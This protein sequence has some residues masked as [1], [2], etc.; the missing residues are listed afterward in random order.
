MSKVW[1]TALFLSLLWCAGWPENSEAAPNRSF[2]IELTPAEGEDFGDTFATARSLGLQF[3]SLS[4]PWDEI[5]TAPGQFK[6]GDLESANGFFP[7]QSVPL[8]LTISVIDTNILRVPEDLREQ[9]FSSPQMKARFHALLDFVFKQLKDTQLVALAIGNEV[10]ALLGEDEQQWADYLNFFQDAVSYTHARKRGT[11]VGV[12]FGFDG[13]RSQR[14]KPFIAASDTAM[15]TY[16]PLHPDFTVRPPSEVESDFGLM[17]AASQ[18]KTLMILECGFP[19]AATNGSSESLQ[20]DFVV[21]MFKAWDTYAGSISH[22]SYFSLTDFGDE[23]VGD[24]GDYYGVDSKAFVSYLSSLG[25]R[26][27][28][29]KKKVAFD[30]LRGEK[31]KLRK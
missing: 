30:V 20:R 18:G 26:A 14:A 9:S 16:Y 19:S 11:L 31:K 6:A 28:N 10:D 3:S 29:G 27:T 25:V 2:S 21:A 17:V 12:K 1:R 23:V 22:L 15:T 4:I 5:E 24:L 7:S 8:V 13:L